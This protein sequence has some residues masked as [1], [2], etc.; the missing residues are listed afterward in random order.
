ML[1]V[2]IR[3]PSA[4]GSNTTVKVVEPPGAIGLEG[5]TVTV[6]SPGF[7]PPT[8]TL[9]GIPVRLRSTSPVFLIVNTWVTVPVRVEVVEKLVRSIRLGVTSPST[10]EM[11]FPNTSISACA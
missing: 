5:C 3:K 1:R 2:A 7:A 4:I 9:L 10:I 11:L 6:K 8:T